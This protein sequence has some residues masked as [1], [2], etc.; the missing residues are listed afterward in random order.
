MSHGAE[1]MMKTR[2]QK[3]GGGERA[4]GI[5][6]EDEVKGGQWRVWLR[7]SEATERVGRLNLGLR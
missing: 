2:W 5:E 3:K 6:A 4:V 1:K 7:N